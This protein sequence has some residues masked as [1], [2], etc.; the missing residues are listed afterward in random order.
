M[1]GISKFAHSF[2][3]FQVPFPFH[4]AVSP[5][6]PQSGAETSLVYRCPGPA[7]C[8]L[9]AKQRLHPPQQGSSEPQLCTYSSPFRL[10]RFQKQI[11]T[12]GQPILSIPPS[13]R[14]LVPPALDR[15]LPATL[16]SAARAANAPTI[17][18][19]LVRSKHGRLTRPTATRLLPRAL[20]PF[21]TRRTFPCR[22]RLQRLPMNI[23]SV[24]PL[25]LPAMQ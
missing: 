25:R 6:Y 21:S 10:T 24:W 2:S 5:L 13:S 9:Y 17:A 16:F 14:Q 20:L 12:N 7:V 22:A 15:L 3:R 11:L 8:D 1:R 18:L 19:G 4:D 23:T